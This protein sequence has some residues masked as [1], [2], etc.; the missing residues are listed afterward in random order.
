MEFW[1]ANLEER[2]VD[3][4]GPLIPTAD[5]GKRVRTSEFSY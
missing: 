4:I 1:E 3:T 2:E 5:F